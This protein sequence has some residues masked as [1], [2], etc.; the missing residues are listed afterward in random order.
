MKVN[1]TY[2]EKL[3]WRKNII[4]FLSSQVISLFGSS[5][6]QYAILWH[7]TLSTES[8]LMMTF[9][10]ICGFIPTFLLSPFAG[11][12]ADRYNRKILIILS[13]GLIALATL[14]L[15]ILFFYG[16]DD[17]WLLFVIAAIRAFGS[18]VQMPAIG[19]ILPQIVPKDQLTKVNGINGS[20]QAMVLFVSPMV[21]ALLFSITSLENIF[22]I[23]VVT[24]ALAISVL[25]FFL[26]IK[27]H[28]KAQ[29]S[30]TVSYFADFKIGL[31]YIRG[32]AYLKMF[33]FFLAIFLVMMA[34]ASFLTPIQVARSFGDDVWRLSA[35]E[36]AFSIGMMI[37]GGLIASWGG[38]KN[39]I[40]TQSFAAIVMG[41]S[42]FA[43]GVVPI[44]WI[45]L[46]FMLIF[47]V[48]IPIFNTPANVLLQE[49]VEEDLLGRVFGIMSMIS[50]AMMPLGM[51]IFGPLA[52][53]ISIESLLI[54]TGIVLIMIAIF[55]GRNKTLL[56]AGKPVETSVV[57][58]G[59]T[60]EG[61]ES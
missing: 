61:G 17:I 23:D 38:F 47:G 56:E 54:G 2:D 59:F 46:L 49:K 6:V 19:A 35:I 41:V 50:T 22:L 34:P 55:F 13:D 3:N 11:V 15:A 44:F 4:L 16:F 31:Q 21:G 25:L 32:H 24:A 51:L 20:L 40:T 53:Y 57:N 37:G 42:T 33:F 14:V 12:W 58:D 45:Y 8:G 43:L 9:Y 52:D 29:T 39:R 48:V 10:I 7:I 36:V 26:K 1:A 18:G 28:K 5:I 30:Q 60:D 27:P